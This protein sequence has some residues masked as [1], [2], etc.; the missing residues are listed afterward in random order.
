MTNAKRAIALVDEFQKG[1]RLWL[2]KSKKGRSIIRVGRKRDRAL[3]LK[4]IGK[5]IAPQPKFSSRRNS[6]PSLT[7]RSKG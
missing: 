4:V 7:D 5:E 1:D 2:R 6:M 3:L